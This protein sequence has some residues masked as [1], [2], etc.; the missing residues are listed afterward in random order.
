MRT[1]HAVIAVMMQVV[2][3]AGSTY[4]WNDNTHMAVSRAAGYEHWYNSASADVTKIKAG[5]REATNHW[6]NNN[7]GAE[8]TIA[9]VL[10]QAERYNDPTDSEGHLLGAIIASLRDYRKQGEQPGKYGRY[11]MA[12]C[13]HYIGDLGMPLHNAPYN[14]F[15][16]A[17]HGENDGIVDGNVLNT[18]DL[19]RKHMEVIEIRDENDL[20]REIARL[21]N[22]SRLMAQKLEKENRNLTADEAYAQL[23][24]S[25][26]LLR[27][28]LKYS[29]E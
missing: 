3:G 15:N 26:S 11:H 1:L 8:V 4:A 14:A 19:I 16:K 18:L 6:F 12:F 7:A 27:A 22:S 24:R 13:A 21:A 20:A 23:S 28:I 2:L 9:M 29:R 10:S 25:A 17:H 5:D